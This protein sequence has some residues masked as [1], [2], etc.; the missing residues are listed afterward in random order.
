MSS[1]LLRSVPKH[2][3]KDDAIAKLFAGITIEF[4]P[5]A[6]KRYRVYRS[7][8]LRQETLAHDV[9]A[10]RVAPSLASIKTLS[11]CP[12]SPDRLRLHADLNG[13]KLNYQSFFF[14]FS[15]IKTARALE[16][17]HGGH[18]RGEFVITFTYPVRVMP[19]GSPFSV[20][21]ASEFRHSRPPAMSHALFLFTSPRRERSLAVLPVR[22]DRYEAGV[23]IN[24]PRSFPLSQRAACGR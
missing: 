1:A 13:P 11:R 14:F 19:T 12:E 8:F 22:F 18:T 9:L 23:L 24:K 15:C 2:Q 21:R 5:R 4:T 10:R 17:R 20:N 6:N 16:A 7:H 3:H